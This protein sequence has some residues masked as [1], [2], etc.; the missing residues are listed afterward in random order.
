MKRG[1]YKS[2]KPIKT[3]EEVK[4]IFLEKECILLTDFFINYKQKLEY[5]CPNGH[6]S[7]TTLTKLLY[8]YR[9]AKCFGSKKHTLEYVKEFFKK[10]NCELLSDNYT[11]NNQKLEYKCS[12]GNI[13]EIR[14]RN[15]QHGQKCIKCSREKANNTNKN[16]H[17]GIFYFQSNEFI[18]KRKE[19]YKNN[20]EIVINQS[21]KRKET[22]VKKFGTH[23]Y[24][25]S[26]EGR[27]KI[28]ENMIKKYGVKYAMQMPSTKDA[29]KKT[30]MKKYGVP[31]LAY[32]SR[33]CSK[34]SQ[35]LFW[36]LYNN[37]KIEDKEKCHFAELNRE[38]VV[39]LNKNYYK[40][41]F[42]N[43][44]LK[45]A[46]EYNGFNFH[47]RNEQNENDTGWCAFH[48][49]LTVKEARK[50]EKEKYESLTLRNYKILTVW[51]YEYHEDFN[52]LVKKCLDF[53]I[54]ENQP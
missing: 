49:N 18:N 33:P 8:G 20:P 37:L 7:K 4:N 38:F 52:I 31:N 26:K 32:L 41:D 45:K 51:D 28:E 35:K 42:V 46:I 10:N 25:G 44:K 24:L 3:I 9:C 30:L 48:P 15:F 1:H 21:K 2:R 39:K 5:I 12:C 53:L 50:Y 43:S 27:I 47:P 23:S 16:N 6:K 13:S 17:N 36:E 40:F 29:F 22:C 54:S 11:G 14:F 19:L 34:E